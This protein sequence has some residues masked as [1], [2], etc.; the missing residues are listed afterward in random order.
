MRPIN[1]R[2]LIIIDFVLL[3]QGRHIS[4]A[5]L[6]IQP[7]LWIRQVVWIRNVPLLLYRNFLESCF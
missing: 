1:G 3:N 6:D 5:F 4:H 2:I 7:T